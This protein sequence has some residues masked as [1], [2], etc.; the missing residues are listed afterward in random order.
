MKECGN[1]A[2]WKRCEF[3]TGGHG[4]CKRTEVEFK[5]MST[6]CCGQHEFKNSKI[7][8]KDSQGFN[9]E[10]GLQGVT[11]KEECTKLAEH[12]KNRRYQGR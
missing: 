6:D 2:F 3:L 7:E 4:D 11:P 12:I 8:T 5:K 10:D 1:C 9:V